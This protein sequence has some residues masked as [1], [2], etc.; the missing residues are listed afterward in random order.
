[1]K[2]KPFV[3]WFT[4]L[5]GAGKSTIS[6]AVVAE[7]RRR[8]LTV[9]Y[10]DGDIVRSIFG[11]TGFTKPERDRHLKRVGFVAS[12]LEF[13]GVPVIASFVSPYRETR[14]FLRELCSNYIEV[15]VSTSLNECEKRDVKGLY[16]RARSGEISNFTGISDD[17]EPPLKPEL[18]IDTEKMTKNES[19]QLVI[20]YIED[21]F[22]VR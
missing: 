13:Y 17:Y 22:T 16:K 14:D 7:L 9:E 19:V 1:M 4:G 11:D 15:Y 3:M 2:L 20:K 18:Q 10:L 12:R 21:N 6:E 5:S 8:Q